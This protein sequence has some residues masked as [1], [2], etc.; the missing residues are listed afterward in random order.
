MKNLP[1]AEAEAALKVSLMYRGR[2]VSIVCNAYEFLDCDTADCALDLFDVYI[3]K[4]VDATPR[5]IYIAEDVRG[6]KIFIYRI[7]GEDICI[8]IHRTDIS[9]EDMCKGLKHG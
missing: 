9:C 8:C 6:G 1:E 5:D 3:K 7:D 2:T 4:Y